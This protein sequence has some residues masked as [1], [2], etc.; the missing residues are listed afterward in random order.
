MGLA[1]S[2]SWVLN[3]VNT[4]FAVYDTHG[5]LQPGWPKTFQDFFG[6]PSPGSCAAGSIPFTSDPREAYD[7]NTSRFIAAAL[8]VEGAFGVNTCPFKSLYWIAVSQTSDPRGSWN[9]YSFDMTLGTTNGADFTMIGFDDQAV[10]FSANMFDSVTSNYSYAEIFG[11]SKARME[12][13]ESVT[14]HGFFNLIVTGPAGAFA[15]DTVQPVET[16]GQGSGPGAEFFVDTFNGFDTVSGHFCTSAADACAGLAVWAFHGP[17]SSPSLAFSYVGNTKAYTFS[18]AADQTSC[19]QCL[20]PSDLRISATPIYRDGSIYA[21][22]ESGVD[23]GTQVVPGIVWSQ[24]RVHAAGGQVDATQ[25]AGDYF[26]FTGDNAVV[27]P[28]FMPNNQGDVFMVFDR[29]SS[30]TNPEVR[31]TVRPSGETDFQSPGVLIKAG[32]A[33]YRASQC[34]T[35]IPVCRWG[36]FS[37]TSYDGFETNHVW[38]AGQYANAPTILRNW[39]TFVGELSSGE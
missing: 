35:V 11:A 37:A 5:N 12:A 39:G 32:E 19:I 8:E 14:A 29:M 36:D 1:A 38:F 17:V 4:S 2:P 34:G 15:V 33:P 31:L 6:V 16:E 26:N 30:S 23:N 28:A 22:W 10:Y 20:D 13:G 3:G 21:G 9:I 24:L 27:Y 25:V 7:P 18:P